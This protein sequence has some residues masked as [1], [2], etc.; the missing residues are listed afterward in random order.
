M[1]VWKK[2]EKIDSIL[3][4]VLSEGGYYDVCKEFDVIT[5]WKEIVGEKI[6]FESDCTKVE[7]NIL[8]VKVYS[9]AWRQ[10][11]IYLKKQIL[12][13]VRSKKECSTIKDIF[14]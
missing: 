2:P 6:A 10:E 1:S 4:N 9:A 7:N 5:N 12:L 13:E 11:I 14:F 8:Y 3:G